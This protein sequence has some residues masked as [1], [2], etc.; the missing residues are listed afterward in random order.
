MKRYH[1]S[2]HPTIFVID[3]EGNIRHK[4]IRGKFLD[5]AVD[6]LLAELQ[7]TNWH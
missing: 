3:A 6:K 5:E 1:V 4:Q 2:S 7:T